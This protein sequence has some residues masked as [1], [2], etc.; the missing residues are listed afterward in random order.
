MI[1]ALN[2]KVVQLLQVEQQ[3]QELTNQLWATEEVWNVAQQYST[4]LHTELNSARTAC[5][6]MKQ[7]I[8]SMK[9]EA[10]KQE[11]AHAKALSEKQ[12]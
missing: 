1:E 12:R 11:T 5:D 9:Q 6:Q 4:L 10:E 8:S 2:Q 3:N 7:Q